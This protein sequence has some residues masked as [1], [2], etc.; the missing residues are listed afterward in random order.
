MV[1]SL[2]RRLDRSAARVAELE[3]QL[4]EGKKDS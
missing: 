3:R 1:R 4:G 2:A